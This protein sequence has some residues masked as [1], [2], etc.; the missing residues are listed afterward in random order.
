MFLLLL[1][2]VLPAAHAVD[3]RLTPSPGATVEVLPSVS[4]GRMDV[5]VY[6]NQVDL[7][8]Q[9]EERGPGIRSAR[10]TDIGGD[11]FPRPGT[12]SYV[13]S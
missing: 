7:R 10:A 1:S 6:R 11:G 5:M 12:R 3:L 13:V 8:V 4:P 9:V 2:V